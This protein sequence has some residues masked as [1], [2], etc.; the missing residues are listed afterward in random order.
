MKN[1]LIAYKW[2]IVRFLF[3][4]HEPECDKLIILRH[5]VYLKSNVIHL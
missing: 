3:T 4:I 1:M 5:K 2:F